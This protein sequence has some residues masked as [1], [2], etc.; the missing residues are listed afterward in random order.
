MNNKVKIYTKTGDGGLTSLYGGKRVQKSNPKVN[1][2]GTLDEAS[3]LLG[4][5]NSEIND[6][7]INKIISQ[8][9]KDLFLIGSYLA[10]AKINIKNLEN[11]VSEMENLIDSFDMQLPSLSN[12]ILP[13]GSKTASLLYFSRAVVRR[14]EREIVT[15]NSRED[16]DG[17]IIKYVNRLSDLLFI[18][19]RFVNHK[20]G[21]K[22]TIWKI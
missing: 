19:A 13:D 5:A 3:S 18:M 16:V 9:Q 22:E 21:L 7:G 20:A 10:G 14:A 15:L 1:S 6:K 2:Y 12:F 17:L 8:V 4:V 11:R